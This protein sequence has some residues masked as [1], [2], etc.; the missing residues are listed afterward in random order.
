MRAKRQCAQ[1]Y[2]QSDVP[3]REQIPSQRKE[4]SHSDSGATPIE[5]HPAPK[6]I[7]LAFKVLAN[8]HAGDF[9][10]Y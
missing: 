2:L 1:N 8:I 7:N 5:I 9:D 4:L 3:E 6:T 10:I